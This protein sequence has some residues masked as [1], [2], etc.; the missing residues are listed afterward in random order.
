[1]LWLKRGCNLDFTLVA[2][3]EKYFCNKLRTLK[4]ITKAKNRYVFISFAA[5]T[6]N[7]TIAILVDSCNKETIENKLQIHMIMKAA[8]KK[9]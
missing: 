8:F 5:V 6:G 2:M 9:R 1:M 3:P 7:T 4:Y